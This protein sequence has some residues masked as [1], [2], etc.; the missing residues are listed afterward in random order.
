MLIKREKLEELREHLDKK[1]ISL[2]VGP[3]QAGKTTLM[4]ELIDELIRRGEKTI[5]LSLD[6]EKDRPFFDTQELLIQKLR[7]EFGDSK[8]YVFIDEIQ[9]KSDAGLFLKGIY[10][11]DLNYKFIVSGSGSIELKEKIHESLAGRKRI[12]ELTTVSFREFA[13]FS[14]GYRYEGRL[15]DFF[16][17]EKERTDILFLDYLNFGGYPRVVTEKTIFEKLKIINEI[18]RSYIEKDISY[19]LKVENTE[20]FNSLIKILASQIGNMLNYSEIANTLNISAQTAKKYLWYAEKTFIIQRVR[21]FFKNTRKEITKSPVVY[22]NDLGLRNYSLGLAGDIKNSSDI[23]FLFENFIY[24][25]LKEKLDY[26]RGADAIPRFWRTKDR[27]EVD[28]V[29]EFGGGIIPIEAKYKEFK[30]PEIERS[31]RSFIKKYNPPKALIINRNLSF[32]LK[33]DKTEVEFIPYNEFVRKAFTL[34]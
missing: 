7:L 18:Y 26:I 3:R 4:K 10:D 34:N 21:P 27:A 12:F 31:M 15:D 24:L 5:F 14:T 25:I 33:A 11:M 22:F 2:V 8:G 28:F 17:L 19:L 23:G 30:K 32:K 13:D 6:F 16:G 1:E 9:R 20:A 29:L